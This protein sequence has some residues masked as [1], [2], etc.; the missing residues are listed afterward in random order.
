MNVQ[1]RSGRS[2]KRSPAFQFYPSDYLS[3]RKTRRLTLEQRGAWLELICSEWLDG[4]LENDHA[5]LARII[6]V[7]L[8]DFLRIWQGL[9]RCFELQGGKLVNP[10]L[11]RERSYQEENRERWRELG[12]RGNEARHGKK[13]ARPAGE[14]DGTPTGSRTGAPRDAHGTPVSA[15]VGSLPSPLS[16]LPNQEDPTGLH[17]P[18]PRP[19]DSEPSNP[20]P[21]RSRS[22][23]VPA[24]DAASVL[25]PEPLCRD[26]EFERE[27]S[28]WLAERRARGRPVTPEAARRQLAKCASLGSERARQAIAASIEN[29]WTGLFE[30]NPTRVVRPSAHQGPGGGSMR[31]LL[32]G[33]RDRGPTIKVEGRRVG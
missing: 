22:S 31:A 10:R 2:E 28:A 21:P 15:P 13:E 25:I 6:G 1:R 8:K 20:K 26:A 3:G 11:E 19:Q 5:E 27:W 9:D 7:S 30:P 24:A 29:G 32:D 17:P 12:R 16:P 18:T 14:P 33:E 23:R 4:P